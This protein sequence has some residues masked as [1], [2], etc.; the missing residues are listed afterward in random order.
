[1]DLNTNSDAING[2]FGSGTVDT[3]AGG[4]PTL[5]VGSSGSSSVFNGVIQNTAG[6]LALTKNGS[7]TLTLGGNNTYSGA[8]AVNAGT[9][10]LAN[11]TALGSAAGATT[12][13][14]NAV[15]DLNGQSISE[16]INLNSGAA[17]VN[18]SASP[19]AVSG[20]VIAQ[21]SSFT[22]IGGTGDITFATITH[23]NG[24]AQFDVT[25]VN[26]GVI[27]LA[28]TV[29]NGY[30][31]MHVAAGTVILDK[32]GAVG[33]RAT[34]ALFVEGGTAKLG[35][36]TGDQI[37]DGNALTMTSGTFDLNGQTE[38]VG[39]LTGVGGV[40]LN[41]SNATTS[42]LTIGGLNAVGSD[43]YGNITDGTGKIGLIKTGTGTSQ[44][45]QGMNTYSGPTTISAGTLTLVGEAGISN[46][47]SV[48]V[49]GT[50]NIS[51]ND[52]MLSLTGG[53]TLTG[54]GTVGGNVNA[55]SGSVINPGAVGAIGTLT[56]SG[57][58]TLAGKL[59]MELNRTNT[60]SN[61]DQLTVS[62]TPTYGGTLS[63][64]N[65]GQTL[66]V[67]DTFQLFSTGVSGFASVN[68]ATN[69]ATG[70]KYTW[71]NNLA[72]LGSITVATVTSPVNPNPT[73]LVA[74][75]NGNKLELSW[76]ADHTGWKLQVQTNTLSI[77]LG[78]NWVDVP[79]STTVNSVT[80]TINPANGSVFYR[81]VLP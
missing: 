28:G 79:G 73:N 5:T 38:T 65:I 31:N 12:V 45:L 3:V 8:T 72:S 67:G 25:N 26:T 59:L 50:L 2:L 52:G 4:T 10:K 47:V 64:T 69:D 75:V 34:S 36:T 18:N 46:S 77:G 39:T 24:S 20:N 56:V 41:N 6:T 62:G 80:N 51:R 33:Q 1:L 48:T 9:L 49:N 17:I 54:F 32:T 63:V 60:P 22:L 44:T 40:V 37:Y 16:N 74:V 68:L 27:D 53:Q 57:N 76:P 30:M 29:D 14:S 15:L 43:Y 81:M 13:S 42:I 66:H 70:Y 61:C 58:T 19:A 35:G 23:V 7:G 21:N 71:N 78:T 55:L 11:A